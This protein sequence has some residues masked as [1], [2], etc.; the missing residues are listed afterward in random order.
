MR[1]FLNKINNNSVEYYKDEL[2][3]SCIKCGLIDTDDGYI[4]TD[5][6]I[7]IYTPDDI[8]E[9]ATNKIN[10]H[11]AVPAYNGNISKINKLVEE[12]E[13]KLI[14][15][16]TNET[17]IAEE[18]DG[19]RYYIIDTPGFKQHKFYVDDDY[20]FMTNIE[21]LSSKANIILDLIL[22]DLEQGLWSVDMR[23]KNTVT[24][25]DWYKPLINYDLRN[26]ILETRRNIKDKKRRNKKDIDID[27][28]TLFEDYKDVNIDNIINCVDSVYMLEDGML[29]LNTLLE[30]E[31]QDG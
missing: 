21:G 31:E 17:G 22:K 3:K 7:I 13:I 8:I 16:N 14:D 6:D 11:K 27:L 23:D 30:E 28:H 26:N 12:W 18:D 10:K 1:E 15:T 24:L 19:E 2:I 4:I 20:V 25:L 5:N 9:Y 29:D